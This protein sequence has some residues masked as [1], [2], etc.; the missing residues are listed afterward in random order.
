[1]YM[2]SMA[3][4]APR[5]LATPLGTRD[6]S[7]RLDQ[8]LSGL[9]C[10]EG[11]QSL[12]LDVLEICSVTNSC[13]SQELYS[14]H[15]RVKTITS[16]EH[17]IS[18]DNGLQSCKELLYTESPKHLFVA[19]SFP[20]HN[21]T[22]DEAMLQ[23]PVKLK[24]CKTV[25]R[26]EEQMWR[27]M[28]EPAQIQLKLGGEIRIDTPTHGQI[29]QTMSLKH[30]E[31][32]KVL[33]VTHRCIA[34]EC[35]YGLK[36][37]SKLLSQRSHCFHSSYLEFANTVARTCNTK[38]SHSTITSSEQPCFYSQGLCSKLADVLLSHRTGALQWG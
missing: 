25:L 4:N 21:I 8:H 2:Y 20:E 10:A 14:R 38:H 5:V 16:R 1:M 27:N 22:V 15:G 34:D 35:M 26:R 36:D 9:S 23:S 29:W 32:A 37:S 17:D 12:N 11:Y 6:P 28:T 3:I 33:Q 31:T 13:L 7:E 30:E 18:I 24:A 19:L